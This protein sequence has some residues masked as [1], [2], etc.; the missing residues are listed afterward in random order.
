VVP[1]PGGMFW[2]ACGGRIPCVTAG[3]G[4][5]GGGRLIVDREGEAGRTDRTEAAETRRLARAGRVEWRV[6]V[7]WAE[8]G[9]GRPWPPRRGGNGDP[10]FR[11]WRPRRQTVGNLVRCST[12]ELPDRLRSRG[13]IRTGDQRLNVVSRAFAAEIVHQLPAGP[14]WPAGQRNGGD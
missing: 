7:A 13:R 3:K 6:L 2:I 11:Q 4:L 14:T 1:P 10:H 9:R 12:T 5:S 8:K